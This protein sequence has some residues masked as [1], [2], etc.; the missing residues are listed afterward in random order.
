MMEATERSI[1]PAMMS[2]V[3]GRAT[4]P[5]SVKLNVASEMLFQLR[6]Y[7]ESRT[8]I[9]TTRPRKTS[10]STSQ[11]SMRPDARQ[12]SRSGTAAREKASKFKVWSDIAVVSL[13]RCCGAQDVA[14]W[15][16]RSARVQDYRN[17]D[18]QPRNAHLP[19]RRDPDRW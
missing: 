12:G 5:S 1:S 10:S 3:I 6:K 15:A 13:A 9:N 17:N 4:M 19:E 16:P 11:R 7:G 18:H 2:R 14:T 8:F